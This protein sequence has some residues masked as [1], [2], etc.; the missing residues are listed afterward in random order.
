MWLVA[1]GLDLVELD[2]RVSGGSKSSIKN[3][4]WMILRNDQGKALMGLSSWP[5]SYS[6]PQIGSIHFLIYKT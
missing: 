6:Q 1:T 5:W 3:N 4:K 2:A